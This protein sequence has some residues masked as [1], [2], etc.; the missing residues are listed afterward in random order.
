VLVSGHTDYVGSAASN[1]K[2]SNDRAAAVKAYLVAQ[3][4]VAADSLATQGFGAT[5]PVADNGTDAGRARNRRVDVVIT[6]K[7]P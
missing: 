5:Q 2:L 3:G 1:D 4:G 7:N 6:P